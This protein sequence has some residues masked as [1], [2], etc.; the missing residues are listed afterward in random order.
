MVASARELRPEGCELRHKVN[1]LLRGFISPLPSRDG[2]VRRVVLSPLLG[3]PAHSRKDSIKSASSVTLV[4][5]DNSRSI[6]VCR[7]CNPSNGGNH[8][9]LNCYR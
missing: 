7:H 6:L 2:S 5:E 9:H 3:H 1:R 8:V 4:T